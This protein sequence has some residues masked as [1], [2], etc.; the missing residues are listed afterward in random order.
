MTVTV[1]SFG[2]SYPEFF[3]GPNPASAV[4]ADDWIAFAKL[5]LNADRWGDA[6]D[7]GVSLYVAHN[8][9]LQMTAARAGANGA[10]PGASS[11]PVASK[12][13]DKVSVSY[14]TGAATLT[15]AGA[16]N[17]TTYG[18]RFLQLARMFGAGGIQL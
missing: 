4:A 7:M 1:A 10:A 5:M 17:L 6:L 9:A 8:L 16:W 15:D 11:G 2:E 3:T 18:V 12:S 14:D 13:V